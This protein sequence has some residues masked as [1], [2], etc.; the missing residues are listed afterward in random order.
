MASHFVSGVWLGVRFHLERGGAERGFE[1]RFRPAP[2]KGGG[3]SI[4]GVGSGKRIT[5]PRAGRGFH[6]PLPPLVLGVAAL[7]FLLQPWIVLPPE[8]SQILR[9][10]HRTMAWRKNL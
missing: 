8:T 10:L 9:D 7:Q 2:G 3:G 6:D 4:L 5:N 1:I